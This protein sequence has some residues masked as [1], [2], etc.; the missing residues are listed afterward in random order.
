M[1]LEGQAG[2]LIQGTGEKAFS[3]EVAI[4]AASEGSVAFYQEELPGSEELCYSA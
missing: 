4:L 2:S 1:G 3:E